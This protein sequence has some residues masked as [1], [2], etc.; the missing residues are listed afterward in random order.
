MLFVEVIIYCTSTFPF[1]INTA[2]AAITANMSKSKEQMAIDSFLAF[3]AGSILQYINASTV[4]YSNLATST[5]FRAELKNLIMDLLAMVNGTT[6][7][8]RMTSVS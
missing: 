4:M 3:L 6:Y 7:R 2:Y 8:Q 1:P 5:A